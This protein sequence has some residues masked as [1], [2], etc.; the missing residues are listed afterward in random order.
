MYRYLYCT[1]RRG[2]KIYNNRNLEDRPRTL[3]LTWRLCVHEV[4]LVCSLPT[5]LYG[6]FYGTSRE[7]LLLLC[8]THAKKSEGRQKDV[9]GARFLGFIAQRHDLSF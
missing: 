9:R 5:S 2:S 6:L 7:L 1:G 8:L 4:H 3:L